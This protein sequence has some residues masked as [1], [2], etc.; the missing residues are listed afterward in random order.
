MKVRDTIVIIAFT[1][2]Y[3]PSVAKWMAMEMQRKCREMVAGT[4]LLDAELYHNWTQVTAATGSVI[5]A[6]VA[7][8]ELTVT[9]KSC[10]PTNYSSE[11]LCLTLSV[12]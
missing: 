8:Q 12:P 9:S 7:T 6:D 1:T 4:V 11:T 2:L 3:L 10:V 5:K